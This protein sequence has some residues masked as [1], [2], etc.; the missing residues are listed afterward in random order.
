[1]DHGS[2]PNSASQGAGA[3]EVLSTFKRP[4]RREG[5]FGPNPEGA[6]REAAS[7]ASL[8]LEYAM[9]VLRPRSLN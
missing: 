3:Q 5:G 6:R 1:M 7:S 9:H 8:V 4:Q 2:S